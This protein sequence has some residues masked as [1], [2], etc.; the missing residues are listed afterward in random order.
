MTDASAPAVGIQH[1][2]YG[3]VTSVRGSVVDVKFTDR[4]PPIYSL[5]R[6]GKQS[7]IAIEV[8]MH[9]DADHIRGIALNPTQ[10]LARGMKVQNT[11]G[12]VDPVV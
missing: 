8:L 3:T 2:N 4:L 10:G 6:T 12:E 9:L 1:L 7:Q 11:G 5:L